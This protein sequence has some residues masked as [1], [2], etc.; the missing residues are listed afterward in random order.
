MTYSNNVVPR[1]CYEIA[2]VFDFF[3]LLSTVICATL[4]L[5]L[6]LIWTILT[7]F[8]TS[9]GVTNS[10][11]VV[12]GPRAVGLGGWQIAFSRNLKTIPNR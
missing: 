10:W 5:G 11:V 3:R 2:I 4:L 6:V 1:I 8:L 12:V 7:G 9:L